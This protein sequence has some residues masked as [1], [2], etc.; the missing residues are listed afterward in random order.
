MAVGADLKPW[1]VALLLAW[2]QQDS[3]SQKEMDRNEAIYAIQQ[4]RNPF[5]DHPEYAECIWGT[6]NCISTGIIEPGKYE[7]ATISIYP[8]P[9]TEK[10]NIDWEI[11]NQNEKISLDLFNIQGKILYHKDFQENSKQVQID[12]SEY[13][14]GIYW[15]KWKSQTWIQVKKV[16]LF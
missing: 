10:I 8:N 11:T 1:A 7:R 12:L 15:L 16:V 4:N 3:V 6:R 9:T 13:A 5:I 14:P 2:H